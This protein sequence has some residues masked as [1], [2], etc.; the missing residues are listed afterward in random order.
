VAEAKPTDDDWTLAVMRFR[1]LRELEDPDAFRRAKQLPVL[2]EREATAIYRIADTL[3]RTGKTSADLSK[4]TGTAIA[5]RIVAKGYFDDMIAVVFVAWAFPNDSPRIIATRSPKALRHWAGIVHGV[6]E[7]IQRVIDYYLEHAVK[8]R[9]GTRGRYPSVAM[10]FLF[11]TA[12]GWGATIP[13]IARRLIDNEARSEGVS[14]DPDPAMRWQVILKKA[15][16][17]ARGRATK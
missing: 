5:N 9:K 10:Y 6:S 12:D 3:E 4:Y 2:F 13:E 15:R 11:Q 1:I 17:A 7:Q 8:F 16:G 14:D